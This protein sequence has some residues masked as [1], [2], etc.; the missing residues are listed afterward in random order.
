MLTLVPKSTTPFTELPVW[1]MDVSN[2][3]TPTKLFNIEPVGIGTGDVECLT[4]FIA[5]VAQEHCVSPIRLI[6]HSIENKEELP[7]S[8]QSSSLSKTAALNINGYGD[9]AMQCSKIMEAGTGFAGTTHTT[10]VAWKGLFSNMYLLKRQRAWC[11]ECYKEQL[12]QLGFN[13]EKLL[14]C[15]EGVFVCSAHGSYL[16][17]SCPRCLKEQKQLS[18]KSRPGFCSLC[19]AWLGHT[20]VAAPIDLTDSYK[21]YFWIANAVRDLLAASFYFKPSLQTSANLVAN[22]QRC[23]DQTA[24]GSVNNFAY[25]TGTWHVTIRR[26]LKKQTTPTITMMQR[27][28]VALDMPLQ[29]LFLGLEGPLPV[30]SLCSPEVTDGLENHLENNGN[31]GGFGDRCSV[32]Q[33]LQTQLKRMPPVSGRQ[34]A[35]GLGW[36]DSRLSRNYPDQYREIVDRYELFHRP[37]V[38]S[39]D[40]VMAALN[41]A[42][43]ELPP[44]SLQSVLRQLGCKDNGYR[45]QT[46]FKFLCKRISRNFKTYRNKLI[47]DENALGAF[48]PNALIENPPPTLSEVASRLEISRSHFKKKFPEWSNALRRRS[49]EYSC[50]KHDAMLVRIENEI[51]AA[52]IELLAKSV[53]PSQE[54]IRARLSV[55]SSDVTFKR[56]LAKVRSSIRF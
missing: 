4:G 39:D 52:V 32:L 17:Q 26:L 21:K 41:K 5:R 47:K 42:C 7:S 8:L 48:F 12:D 45:I 10:L 56:S 46:R 54:K 34:A 2:I 16:K 11:S 30:G 50:Q 3:Q 55:G 40:D 6:V 43:K 9:I 25:S 38:G 18:N 37:L 36:P 20:S 19:L 53:Y 51:R 35:E 14:W 49:S 13:Y 44:P 27:I 1:R 28:C 33:Y 24:Y 23:I 29:S 22:L 15:I 31:P